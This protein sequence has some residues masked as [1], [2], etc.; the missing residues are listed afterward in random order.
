MDGDSYSALL[1]FIIGFA[2]AFIASII[3]NISYSDINKFESDNSPQS[4]KFLSVIEKFDENVNALIALEILFYSL[5]FFLL[6]DTLAHYISDVSRIVTIVFG[7]GLFIITFLIRTIIYAFGGRLPSK[8]ALSITP[9]L[10]VIYT[11][12]SP[13]INI[14]NKIIEIISDKKIEE[15]YAI[16]EINALVETAHEE[17]SLGKGEYRILKNMMNFRDVH[18]SDVMTPR[19]V[20]FSCEADMS[21]ADAVKITDFKMHSRVPIREG[22][23]LDDGIAGYVMS[24]D[25]F[26]AAIEG[27]LD[28]PLRNFARNLYF[29]PENAELDDALEQ[30][31]IK[32]QHL[33]LVVDEYGGIDGLITMEDVLETI[34]G[35]EIVDEADKV[36]DLRLLAKQKRDRRIAKRQGEDS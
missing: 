15:E 27:K 34:L 20:V 22:N 10:N 18:V 17:G 28:K 33:F 13:L 4:N 2:S 23:S 36:V 30:F 1:F 32:Q 6:V 11:I 8:F 5:G 12:I 3:N 35:T 9:I 21:V 25:I 14:S 24:R 29:I 7:I 16:E 31:L 19:T 26:S